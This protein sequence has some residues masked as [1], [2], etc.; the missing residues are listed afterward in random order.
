MTKK[1]PIFGPQNIRK[2]RRGKMDLR[3]IHNDLVL[4]PISPIKLLRMFASGLAFLK[5][6][7]ND[8]V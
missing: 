1:G 7:R 3:S 5:Q 4:T 6:V 2:S 8:Y